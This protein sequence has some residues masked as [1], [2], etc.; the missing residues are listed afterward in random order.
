MRT[1]IGAGGTQSSA[2]VG[3]EATSIEQLIL[4]FNMAQMR[5]S[6]PKCGPTQTTTHRC[7]REQSEEHQPERRNNKIGDTREAHSFSQK[8]PSEWRLATKS[9]E[10]AATNEVNIRELARAVMLHPKAVVVFIL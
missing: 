5:S 8:Q 1:E 7:R 3:S 9:W 4:V 10:T 6:L 2:I